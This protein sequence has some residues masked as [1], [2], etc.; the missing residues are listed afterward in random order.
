MVILIRGPSP[1]APIPQR[2]I[3]PMPLTPSHLSARGGLVSYGTVVKVPLIVHPGSRR[4]P[5]IPPLHQ[6]AGARNSSEHWFIVCVSDTELAPDNHIRLVLPRRL[7]AFT[8]FGRG[9]AYGG[10]RNSPHELERKVTPT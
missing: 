9:V 4:C 8:A 10:S 5:V 7:R 2:A 1:K 6:A 3:Q